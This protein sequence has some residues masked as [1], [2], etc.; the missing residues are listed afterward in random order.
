MT[1]PEAQQWMRE[2]IA[3]ISAG[4]GDMPQDEFVERGA[5]IIARHAPAAP[6]QT[7]QPDELNPERW[8]T[9][10]ELWSYHETGSLPRMRAE[11]EPETRQPVEGPERDLCESKGAHQV[12]IADDPIYGSIRAAIVDE[13]LA[14][15]SPT[16][17]ENWLYSRLVEAR[18]AAEAAPQTRQ[19]A[20]EARRNLQNAYEYLAKPRP[21]HTHSPDGDASCEGCCIVAELEAV[22]AS[23]QAPS[24]KE[25][26]DNEQK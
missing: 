10:R 22:L 16:P 8:V 19:S 15:G 1:D 20:E 3:E 12:K 9:V 26:S 24:Q 7:R 4:R 21:D 13:W 18:Y 14:A 23:L 25:D 17:K 11:S 5:K 6:S 2:A